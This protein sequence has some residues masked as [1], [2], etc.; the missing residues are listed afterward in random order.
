M[1]ETVLVGLRTLPPSPDRTGAGSRS[2]RVLSLRDTS[3]TM[4]SEELGPVPSPTVLPGGPDRGL[5]IDEVGSVRLVEDP[6][7][8]AA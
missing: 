7:P 4:S 8:A 2:R 6:A 5:S 3:R 1:E